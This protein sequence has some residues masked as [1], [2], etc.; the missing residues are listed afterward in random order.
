MR[1]I[2]TQDEKFM[3]KA[4][5][6]AEKGAGWTNPNP[7]VGA[8]IVK[9]GKIIGH[10]YH[11]RAGSAHAEIEALADAGPRASGATLYTNLEPCP[12]FGKTPPC[13]E[14][15]INAGI[16]RVVCSA[17]DPNPQ[18]QG[19]GVR[20]L[21]QFGISVS[22][23]TRQK[24]ARALNE[25]FFA[26]HE[27]K[28]P[29]VALK[30]AMSLDGKIATRSGGSRWITNEQARKYARSLR[31]NYQ[32]ILVGINTVLQDNPHLGLRISGASEPL[33]IILDGALRI[34][35]ASKVLRDK[36]VLIFT[37]RRA[38]KKKYKK[39][40]REGIQVVT[41]LGNSIALPFVMKE[42]VRREITS[43]FVEGGGAVLGSFIDAELVDKVYAFYA[44]IIIGGEAAVSAVSGKGASSIKQSLRLKN[45]TLKTFGDNIL[46]SGYVFNDKRK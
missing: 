25:A 10:G 19:H 37:T 26:F 31:R 28:R 15:I 29:F 43:V 12:H 23:G 24:E 20:R 6:L 33:R 41:C 18:V 45:T 4:L 38:D 17:I 1:T 39:L 34:S 5:K 8:V 21:K 2:S 9:N 46:I 44:P 35:L 11:R 14:A 22:V 32:A 42:L 30:F 7:M 36:N 27:K 16:K 13:V 40:M 3:D